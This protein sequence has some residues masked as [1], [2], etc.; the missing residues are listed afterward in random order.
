MIPKQI[1]TKLTTEKELSWAGESIAVS[2]MVTKRSPRR[3]M[4][5]LETEAA[6]KMNQNNRQYT[7]HNHHNTKIEYITQHIHYNTRQFNTIQVNTTQHN[8]SFTSYHITSHHIT[9][10]YNTIQYNTIQYN[11]AMNEGW[12]EFIV[13]MNE[14]W[15][16]YFYVFVRE[17][18][19]FFVI[20]SLEYIPSVAV[21]SSVVF[22]TPHSEEYDEKKKKEKRKEKEKKKKRKKQFKWFKEKKKKKGNQITHTTNQ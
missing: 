19:A 3:K 2:A 10:Q 8:T 18:M 15:G 1:A 14:G 11:P 5:W 16:W 13:N 12:V 20:Q 9:I 4:V 22:P 6:E 21:L 7:I 17:W